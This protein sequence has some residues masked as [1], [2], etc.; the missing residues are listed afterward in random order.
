MKK[1]NAMRLLD[2]A[3]IAY[4]AKTYAYDEQDLS[5]VHAAALMDMPPQ[6]VFKTL[7]AKGER[8]G[9]FVCCLPSDAELDLKKAAAAA[10]DKRAELVPLK[11][12]LPLTGY[13]RG[14]CSPVGMKKRYPTVL[15]GSALDSAE[16]SVSGGARGLS[17]VLAG[18]DLADYTGAVVADIKREDKA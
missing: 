14:G 10:G 7:L 1:T 9:Y 16:I 12:L 17:L 3:G 18:R 13:V 5:G 2:G 11:D 15:D 6:Q 8:T 4:A